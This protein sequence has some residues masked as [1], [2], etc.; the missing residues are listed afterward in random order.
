VTDIGPECKRCVDLANE[1]QDEG[2]RL[3]RGMSVCPA[4]S[5]MKRSQVGRVND[6]AVIPS[7]DP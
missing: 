6:S 7:R 2:C 4:E 1:H 5:L 3:R